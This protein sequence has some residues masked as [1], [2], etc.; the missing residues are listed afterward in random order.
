MLPANKGLLAFVYDVYTNSTKAA[1]F[2]SNPAGIMAQ[3]ELTSDQQRVIWS[4]GLTRDYADNNQA[5]S[6]LGGGG[7]PSQPASALED[8]TYPNDGAMVLLGSML[9]GLL[10]SNPHWEDTW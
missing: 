8:A 7:L 10:S 1:A 6:E 4:A 5:W 2:K 9:V 3:Y